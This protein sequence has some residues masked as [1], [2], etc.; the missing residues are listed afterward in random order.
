MLNKGV[1]LKSNPSGKILP[2][3]TRFEHRPAC[4]GTRRL[5]SLSKK[6][7]NKIK[8]NKKERNTRPRCLQPQSIKYGGYD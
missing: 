8:K 4:D 3:E 1:T 6:F 5:L 2:A 7:K